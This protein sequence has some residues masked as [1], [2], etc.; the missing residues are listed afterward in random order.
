MK[1]TIIASNAGVTDVFTRNILDGK[2]NPNTRKGMAVV[3]AAAD[4]YANECRAKFISDLMRKWKLN[5][6]LYNKKKNTS[7]GVKGVSWNK[8][9]NKWQS[10]I[11]IQGKRIHL[12]YYD[13]IEKAAEAYQIAKEQAK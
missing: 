12:G 5:E 4:E 13:S 11:C 8:Y 7:S 9:S 3:L 2:R 10:Q 1:K 6:T